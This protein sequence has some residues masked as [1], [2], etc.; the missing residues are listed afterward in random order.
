MYTNLL[1][2]SCLLSKWQRSC[3][4]RECPLPGEIPGESKGGSVSSTGGILHNAPCIS[5]LDSDT[6]SL[7]Q[8]DFNSQKRFIHKHKSLILLSDLNTTVLVEVAR[9]WWYTKK[10][11]FLIVELFFSLYMWLNIIQAKLESRQCWSA[12][13]VG[14]CTVKWH[15]GS[16]PGIDWGWECL[17][18]C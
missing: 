5:A 8:T 15:V 4:D 2:F 7:M 10:I 12:V 17:T 16:A 11:I 6:V 1:I 14:P 3:N 18:M 9:I 13:I